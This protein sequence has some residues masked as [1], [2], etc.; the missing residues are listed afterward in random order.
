MQQ[1]QFLCCC[2]FSCPPPHFKWPRTPG[3]SEYMY[4]RVPHPTSCALSKGQP[5][6]GGKTLPT[7]LFAAY[8]PLSFTQRCSVQKSLQSSRD[9]IHFQAIPPKTL[10]KISI[11]FMS[12][13]AVRENAKKVM[14][15][16]FGTEDGIHIQ[17]SYKIKEAHLYFFWN[18]QLKSSIRAC[19]WECL[20]I[21]LL[22]K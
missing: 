21:Q 1:I 17:R 8:T 9:R 11:T 19:L 7:V 3:H 13:W 16:L 14:S 20:G 22:S 2:C 6:P 5:Y 4:S 18:W 15:N 10:I 12:A